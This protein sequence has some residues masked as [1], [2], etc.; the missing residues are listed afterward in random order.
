VKS[1]IM[2]IENKSRGL[3][4]PACIGRVTYSR[5]GCTLYYKDKA[6]RSLHGAGFKA[7]YY[8]V[9]T[10]E[11]YWISGCKKRGS[12]RLYGERIPVEIDEDVR[13][14]YWTQIRNQPAKQQAK[15]ADL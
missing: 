15:F 14:E 7:N 9:A 10:G 3:T 5:T 11:R 8:D 6:F 4:G 1:R 12:N 13:R 2:Y